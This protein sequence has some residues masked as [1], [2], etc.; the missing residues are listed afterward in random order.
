MDGI[1][2]TVK[3]VVWRRI[4]QCRVVINNAKDFA[5]VAK[6]AC[7]QIRIFYI[8][9]SKVEN[10]RTEMRDIWEKNAAKQIPNTHGIHHVTAFSPSE[11]EVGAITPFM[12]NL[13]PEMKRVLNIQK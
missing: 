10:V 13:L 7:P 4:M 1:G 5:K 9:Q 12:D 3:R 6:Q 8:P 11:L 2:G